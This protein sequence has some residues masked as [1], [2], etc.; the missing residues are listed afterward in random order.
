MGR[1]TDSPVRCVGDGSATAGEQSLSVPDG[2]LMERP[3]DRGRTPSDREDPTARH[4]EPKKKKW[5]A[6][7]RW[8]ARKI[9]A[10]APTAYYLV[11]LIAFCLD[12]RNG[13]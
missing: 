1:W 12:R 3:S 7:V 4:R 9:T 10:T 6:A 8:L 13:I 2:R 11:G 5:S